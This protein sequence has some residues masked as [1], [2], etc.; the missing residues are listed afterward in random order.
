MSLAA[1]C[2]H[3]AKRRDVW[4]RV[5]GNRASFVTSGTQRFTAAEDAGVG[6][7]QWDPDVDHAHTAM[8]CDWTRPKEALQ[9]YAIPPDG[10]QES[11]IGIGRTAPN[12]SADAVIDTEITALQ[13]A[14][15]IGKWVLL[16]FYPKD[17][18]FV[19]PTEIIA[20]S[21]AAE[22]FRARGC[23]VIGA[24]T[25]SAEVHLAWIRTPR[26]R[27]G[28]GHMQ[29]PLLADVDRRVSRAYGV[30]GA[31][32]FPYRGMFLMDPKGELKAMQIL[33][34][35]VGRSVDEASRLLDAFQYVEEH[36][37]V[38]PANW[39]PGEATMIADPDASMEYFSAASAAEEDDDFGRTLHPVA[40][41]AHYKAAVAQSGPVVVDFMAPWCGKCRMI[42]PHIE[43]LQAAHPGVTF[44]KFD[45]SKEELEGLARDLDVTALPA[46][47]FFKAGEPV[48]PDVTGYKKKPLEEAVSKLAA[49]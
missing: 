9:A 23:E 12:F 13:A 43:A 7:A 35:D 18:T 28:L 16:F 34:N 19:C 14:D 27:G 6:E 17:F 24:S 39:K 26:R 4:S 32:N 20:F 21:D 30:L 31:G 42:A 47:K 41:P 48:L 36:G 29:I 11:V 45:T 1:L 15:Y 37:V 3:A 44:Y 5:F 46:F 22:S 38:C 40:T 49:M 8:L 2:L 33:H 25:D 10:I